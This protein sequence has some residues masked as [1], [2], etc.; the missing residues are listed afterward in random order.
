MEVRIMFIH[1]DAQRKKTWRV[2]ID[3]Q[4]GPHGIMDGAV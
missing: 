2:Y 4:S 3:Y 1:S